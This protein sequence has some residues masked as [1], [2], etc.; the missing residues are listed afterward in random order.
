MWVQTCKTE[1]KLTKSN[2]RN[3]LARKFSL[4]RHRHGHFV[5]LICW[6][7][8]VLVVSI[9]R[10]LLSSLCLCWN[11]KVAFPMKSVGSSMILL[12]HLGP[13][14]SQWNTVSSV[15]HHCSSCPESPST[16]EKYYGDFF[17]G[18]KTTPGLNWD[19]GSWGGNTP[20]SLKGFL[21]PGWSSYGRK[22]LLA[23]SICTTL[24]GCCVSFPVSSMICEMFWLEMVQVYG[25]YR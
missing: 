9:S 24:F 16:F 21:V 6:G 5:R 1:P 11:T 8:T 7:S 2:A 3:K 20:N 15:L 22:V 10:L 25:A 12:L 18:W 4:L 23:Q 13:K 14:A 17:E 19:P